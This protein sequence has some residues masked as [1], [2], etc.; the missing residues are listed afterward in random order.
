MLVNIHDKVEVLAVKAHKNFGIPREKIRL[1]R[2]GQTL[3]SS[4]TIQQAG[5][6]DFDVIIICQQK[7]S[8]WRLSSSSLENLLKEI[9]PMPHGMNEVL[10]K[11]GDLK[12]YPVI[13]VLRR[14][15][16]FPLVFNKKG[17]LWDSTAWRTPTKTL[18]PSGKMKRSWKPASDTLGR[19]TWG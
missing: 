16:K 3:E 8:W 2:N 4:C 19:T 17:S 5:L 6:G 1:L 10:E 11:Y 18:P 15:E 7:S 13:P 14:T 12:E 9:I